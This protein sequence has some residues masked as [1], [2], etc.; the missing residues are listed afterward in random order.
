MPFLSGGRPWPC[1]PLRRGWPLSRGHRVAGGGVLPAQAGVAPRPM[2]QRNGRGRAPRSGGGGPWFNDP[3]A[4]ASSCSPL[5]RGWP[6]GIFRRRVHPPVLPAQAGVAPGRRPRPRG[7]ARAPRSGGGGPWAEGRPVLHGWCSPLRRGWPLCGRQSRS[8]SSVLP[9]QA[10]VAPTARVASPARVSAPR[11]GGGGPWDFYSAQAVEQCSPLRRGWPLPA[12]RRPGMG[13]VLPAQAGVAPTT[14]SLTGL[15]RCAPRSGGGGP[16]G[17]AKPAERRMVLPAQAGVAPRPGRRRTC[18]RRAPRSGGGGPLIAPGALSTAG[19]SPLRRGWPLRCPAVRGGSRVLPAQAGVAPGT[20]RTSPNGSRAPCSGGG[21]PYVVRRDH[22]L[23]QCSPLRRGWPQG[24]ARH[25]RARTVLPAQAGVAPGG[26][27]AVP[28]R[29]CAPRSGGGGPVAATCRS[30]SA[31]C[32]PLRR[33][34]PLGRRLRRSSS[35]VLPAQAG[36]APRRARRRRTPPSAPRSGGG[37]PC[38]VLA[39]RW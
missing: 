29:R 8:T 25:Q 11:S 13:R 39:V 7:P 10:G 6:L 15:W 37:G 21:G 17:A 19:C 24:H 26:R 35:T 31:W 14:V 28:G 36:V 30:D 12:V 3:A 38:R 5:R 18:R 4:Q 1:S 9:A 16:L 32:S 20:C 2:R 22:D 27:T 33:G 34:W 23:G